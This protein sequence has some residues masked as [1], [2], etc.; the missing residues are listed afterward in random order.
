[1]SAN[2]FMPVQKH[3][4]M[5]KVGN[6]EIPSYL[7]KKIDLPKS[8]LCKHKNKFDSGQI[9]SL[10]LYDA[11]IPS[12][13]KPVL[14]LLSKNK[15]TVIEITEIDEKGNEI[16][17]WIYNGVKIENVEFDTLDWSDDDTLIIKVYFHITKNIEF[18]SLQ[19]HRP[20]QPPPSPLKNRSIIKKLCTIEKDY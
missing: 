14:D 9:H 20:K 18:K 12:G 4:F 3:R 8:L 15:L 13:V 1:M 19:I 17:K 7:I 2:T 10:E 11:I 16:F 5:V 6:N